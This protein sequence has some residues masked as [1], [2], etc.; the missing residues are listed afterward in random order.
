MIAGIA[1][2]VGVLLSLRIVRP[3]QHAIEGLNEGATQVAS[4]SGQVSSASQSLAEGSSE[5]AAGLEETSSSIEEM[6]SMT[7]QNADNANQANT[8]MTETRRVVDEANQ[9]HGRIDGV[10]GGDLHGQ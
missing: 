2:V 4:A 6:S 9:C 7:K 1:L 8:L 5:Q 3:I 10:H